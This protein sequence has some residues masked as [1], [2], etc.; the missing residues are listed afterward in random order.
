ML[1][2]MNF[3]YANFASLHAPCD[4]TRGYERLLISASYYVINEPGLRR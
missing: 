3:S 4:W 1:A 2:S